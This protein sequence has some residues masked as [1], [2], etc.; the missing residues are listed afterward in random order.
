M[1]CASIHL[2][3]SALAEVPGVLSQCSDA[4]VAR[5]F[6]IKSASAI[7]LSFTRN[8][9]ATRQLRLRHSRRPTA[10]A[11]RARSL[12]LRTPPVLAAGLLC[13]PPETS[14]TSENSVR[15][16]PGPKKVKKINCRFLTRRASSP[17]IEQAHL[18]SNTRRSRRSTL[19]PYVP[20]KH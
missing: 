15:V 17:S 6:G 20:C 18:L 4:C 14:E 1:K 19:S 13:A 2:V 3:S 12:A 10:A 5:R 8:N 11:G 16:E 7:E 9:P